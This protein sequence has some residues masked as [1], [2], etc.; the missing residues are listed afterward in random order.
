MKQTKISTRL[1]SG[2]LLKL[3]GTLSVAGVGLYCVDH[4]AELTSDIYE[5]PFTVNNVIIEV[6]ADI[7]QSQ[8]VLNHMELATAPAMIESSRKKLLELRKSAAKNMALVREQYMGPRTDVEDID[9]AMAEWRTALDDAIRLMQAGRIAEAI[10][11]DDKRVDP[12][13]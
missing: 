7:L 1:F 12:V 9:K 3:L 10:T 8:V 5:H 11:V 13:G 6:R 2:F 4:L